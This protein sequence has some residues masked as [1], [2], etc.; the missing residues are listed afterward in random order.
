ML[1]ISFNN[2]F[3]SFDFFC[4]IF[5]FIF[6]QNFLDEKKDIP[7]SIRRSQP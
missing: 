3:L 6:K 1:N 5:P 2:Q 7:L 4:V